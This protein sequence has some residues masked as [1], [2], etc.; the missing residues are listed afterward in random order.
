MLFAPYEVDQL[1]NGGEVASRD[2]AQRVGED[3]GGVFGEDFIHQ[4][5]AQYR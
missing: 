5:K 3:G 2:T 1:E 4:R